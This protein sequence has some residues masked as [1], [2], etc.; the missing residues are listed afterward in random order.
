MGGFL[1]DAKGDPYCCALPYFRG[2]NRL[3]GEPPHIFRCLTCT[4]FFVRDRVRTRS[5]FSGGDQLV[6]ALP[7]GEDSRVQYFT[8]GGQLLFSRGLYMGLSHPGYQTYTLVRRANQG[9]SVEILDTGHS[10]PNT[11]HPSFRE[12]WTSL[13]QGAVLDEVG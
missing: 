3:A 4:R 5:G 1:R 8:M 9:A 2:F 10:M 7:W 12:R 13:E 6:T 11:L